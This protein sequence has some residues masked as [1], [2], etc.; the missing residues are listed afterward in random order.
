MRD[1]IDADL[2]VLSAM[3]GLLLVLFLIAHLAGL[4]PALIAPASFEAYA[5]RLH[6]SAWLPVLEL[7]LGLTAVVHISLTI[8]TVILNR[9]AGN[10]ASLASRRRQPLASWATRSRLAAG[11][12]TLAFLVVHLMQLRLPRPVDGAER[13]VL[14]SVLHQPIWALSYSAAAVAVGLH[15]LHGQEAA[16]RSMG[17]LTPANADTIRLGGRALAALIG[18]GFLIISVFT[19]MG[20]A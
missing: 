14:I 6:H 13:A 20:A 2:R 16:H 18:G 12:I 10:S 17:W 19:G 4:V 9:R 15:L 11:L 5:I 7:A 8:R 1:A 3:S